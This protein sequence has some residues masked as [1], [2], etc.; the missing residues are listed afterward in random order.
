L[1]TVGALGSFLPGHMG[2]LGKYL[3]VVA[4][5]GIG[6]GANLPRMIRTGPKPIL[7][8]LLVWV[9]VALTSLGVQRL[10]GQF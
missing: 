3:I 1:N 5:S 10:A 8:G 9:L 4:L 6:L 7:L 2:S